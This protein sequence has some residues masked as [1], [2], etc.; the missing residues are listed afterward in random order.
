[1]KNKSSELDLHQVYPSFV[2]LTRSRIALQ[3]L[4]TVFSIRPS[5]SLEFVLSGDSLR[6]SIQQA[7]GKAET[8]EGDASRSFVGAKMEGS[9]I[10]EPRSSGGGYDQKLFDFSSDNS[11]NSRK[12]NAMEVRL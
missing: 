4:G 3:P 7:E 11:K 5:T 12:K 1:M 6:Q 9:K 8:Q 10:N 2:A